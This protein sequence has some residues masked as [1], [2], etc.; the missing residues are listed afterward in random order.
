MRYQTFFFFSLFSRPRAGLATV[1]SSFFRVGNHCAECE[2]QQQL[3]ALYWLTLGGESY[4]YAIAW[5]DKLGTDPMAVIGMDGRRRRKKRDEG[6]EP[7][8]KQGVDNKGA[9][10]RRDERGQGKFHL[11]VRLTTTRVGDHTG[12]CPTCYM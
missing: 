4:W 3:L 10:A 1:L 8:R 7:V 11:P 5:P 2:K 9:D 6:E 12:R